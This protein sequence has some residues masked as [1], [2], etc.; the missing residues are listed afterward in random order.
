[1]V[2]H[3]FQ[4]SNQL[5]AVKRIGLFF[6]AEKKKKKKKKRKLMAEGANQQSKVATGSVTSQSNLVAARLGWSIGL[7]S[8]KRPSGGIGFEWMH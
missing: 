6:N 4:I 5:E 2:R 8:T 1:L 3:L 7:V